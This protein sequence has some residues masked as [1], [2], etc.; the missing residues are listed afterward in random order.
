MTGISGS[1]FGLGPGL[2]ETAYGRGRREA[3]SFELE[4]VIVRRRLANILLCTCSL[5]KFDEILCIVEINVRTI[6][7]FTCCLG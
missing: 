3:M 2:F 6:S 5:P 4:R 1:A 7:E